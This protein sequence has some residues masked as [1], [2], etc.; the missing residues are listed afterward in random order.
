M[1]QTVKLPYVSR[2]ISGEQLHLGWLKAVTVNNNTSARRLEW[3]AHD[4][5]ELIFPLWGHYR[6][7]FGR[8]R[9]VSLGNDSFVAIPGGVMHRLNE[10][11]DPPGARIHVYLKD[12]ADRST[13][14]GGFTAAEYSRLY[15]TLSRRPLTRLRVSPRLKSALSPLG[16]II[17]SDPPHL[18]GDAAMRI[19]F[20]CC[21]VLCGC[22]SRGSRTDGISD[23]RIIGEAVKWLERNHSSRMHMDRLVAHIGYSR[24]RL[25]ALFKKQMNLTPLEYLRNYRIEKAKQMLMRTELPAASVGKSCGLGTPAQFAHLFKKMTGLTPLAYRTSR[26]AVSLSPGQHSIRMSR[27]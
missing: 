1:K 21:L 24:S 25:F 12:P 18:D 22:V 6:Y 27:K 7:E 15:Q 14:K 5:L 11:I 4:E 9:A 2:Y 26:S 13:A 23:D 10:A 17:T 8:R 20:L 16:R 3:H 19:R